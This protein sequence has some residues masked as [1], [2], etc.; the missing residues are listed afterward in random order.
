MKKG[1]LYLFFIL[2]VILVFSSGALLGE[3]V[4]SLNNP[5]ESAAHNKIV[6][7]K[8]T[9]QHENSST[10]NQMLTNQNGQVDNTQDNTSSAS[11]TIVVKDENP[12]TANSDSPSE[13]PASSQASASKDNAQ[14]QSQNSGKAITADSIESTGK[15]AYLTFDDG[16]TYTT[17][18]IL[19][20]LDKYNIKATFFVVGSMCKNNP[21]ILKREYA[22]GEFICNHTYSHNYAYI[23][24][25]TDNF[26]NDV[27]KCEKE[28][29]SILGSSYKTTLV[30]FP[31]GST[32]NDYI[33]GR[34]S[35]FENSLKNAG[36]CYVDWNALSGDAD[37][38]NVP[39]STL[40][41]NV[42]RTVGNKKRVIILMHDCAIKNTVTALPAIIEYLKAQGYSFRTLK[43][44]TK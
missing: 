34:N 20:I 30:R 3:K 16:P 1:I 26:V 28:I 44:F 37:A 39:V 42:K 25:N 23:Y 15:V 29:Q 13:A 10:S 43:D 36:Y 7:A 24:K 27:K 4:S 9:S 11:D 2:C 40:I 35:E 19:N 6:Q 31:G 22:D 41:S 18:E 33:K 21:S 5:S 8:P 32:E 12:T 14:V 38:K 17:P